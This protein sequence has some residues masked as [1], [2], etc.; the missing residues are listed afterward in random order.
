MKMDLCQSILYISIPNL[1]QQHVVTFVSLN[2]SVKCLPFYSSMLYSTFT[3]F[4][5][6]IALPTIT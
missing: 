2:I 6:N 1:S 5:F 4:I 3:L